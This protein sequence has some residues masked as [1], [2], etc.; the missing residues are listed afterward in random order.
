MTLPTVSA[1]LA[2]EHIRDLERSAARHNAAPPRP[3]ARH[4]AAGRVT[5]ALARARDWVRRGQLGSA[6]NYCGAC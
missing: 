1:A 6:P 4:H 3:A 2:A 5:A